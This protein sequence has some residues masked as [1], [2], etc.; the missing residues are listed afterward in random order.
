[1]AEQAQALGG[2]YETLRRLAVGGMG[3]VFLAR[4]RGRLGFSRLVVIKRMLPQ[5]ARNPK[6][7]EMFADEARII[8]NLS[9]PNICQ[10]LELGWD[11]G[12]PFLA[13][14]YVRGKSL[15]EM[16]DE[17]S[18]SGTQISR[19]VTLR[20]LSETAWALHFA[21]EARD[22][23]DRPLHVVHRDI[24]P[25]NVMVTFHGDVKLMDFGVARADNRLHRTD[26]GK[27]KGKISY[28]APE[29]LRGQPLDRRA[30]VFAV[31]VMLW[32]LTL[33]RR[34]FGGDEV[35]A[36]QKAI[37]CQVPPPRSIDPT[38][39]A[40]L[41][42]IVMSAL[43]A[44]RDRRTATAAELATALNAELAEYDGA[45][46]AD[47]AAVMQ[48]LFPTESASPDD[49]D[50]IVHVRPEHEQLGRPTLPLRAEKPP[51]DVA[52]RTTLPQPAEKPVAVEPARQVR[53]TRW[54]PLAV[55]A[56]L[57]AGAAVLVVTAPWASDEAEPAPPAPPRVAA[58]TPPPRPVDAPE[59][60][61]A[62]EMIA[63]VPVD[64]AV[65]TK[66]EAPAHPRHVEHVSRPVPSPPQPQPQ[67]QPQPL[68]KSPE[69][70][71]VPAAPGAI[72]VSSDRVG[73]VIIDGTPRKSTPFQIELPAGDHE[74]AL[75]LEE[76]AGTLHARTRVQPGKKTKCKAEGNTLTCAS[77]P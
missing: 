14:E 50:T 11:D 43:A 15:A 39:P 7:V 45:E 5:V 74:L 17:A 49:A 28:M 61:D 54:L 52:L 3:E 59:A 77:S 33:N 22:A 46:R 16:W 71:P 72:A 76:G 47:V 26:T 68:P 66:H 42:R 8:G 36:F 44:D 63:E 13:L 48:Q 9:H 70:A 56:L 25:Q 31:G 60:P 37:D 18:V 12:L 69:Q 19:A 58:S 4:E 27:I 67:P 10:I 6:F 32:E 34:L 40:S 1:M 73:L 55:F 24:S 62:T 30:D 38:Y 53:R 65:E 41:E 23:E 2:K 64:A 35:Q 75:E 21:H 57:A 51:P 20:T 29:Q